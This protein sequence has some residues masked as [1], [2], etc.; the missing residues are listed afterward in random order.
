MKSVT[1]KNIL[2][3]ASKTPRRGAVDHESLVLPGLSASNVGKHD[4]ECVESMRLGEVL[5][6]DVFIGTVFKTAPFKR[7]TVR[8]N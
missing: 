5:D 3:L 4:V 2:R 8:E 7:H 6:A 1:L